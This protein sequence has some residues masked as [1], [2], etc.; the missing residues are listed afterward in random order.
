[1]PSFVLRRQRKIL[2]TKMNWEGQRL[3]GNRSSQPSDDGGG[4][5]SIGGLG[6]ICLLNLPYSLVWQRRV[7]PHLLSLLWYLCLLI[8]FYGSDHFFYVF[9][10]VS[11]SFSLSHKHWSAQ[12]GI[13]YPHLVS[14]FLCRLL[15][16]KHPWLLI[17]YFTQLFIQTHISYFYQTPSWIF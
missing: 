1:M 13:L 3:H 8:S 6:Q 11:S 16:T 12:G 17:L 5:N 7:F 15:P 4:E 9:F 2:Q 14:F 10:N